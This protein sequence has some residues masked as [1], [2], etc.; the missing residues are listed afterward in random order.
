MTLIPQLLQLL[1]QAGTLFTPEPTLRMDLRLAVS[2]APSGNDISEA[3]DTCK[4]N[5]WV[6]GLRDEM[7]SQLK[8]RITDTGRAVLDE[9]GL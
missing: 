6:I 3:I 7:T 9:R 1:R 4:R 5:G 8:W 2:P